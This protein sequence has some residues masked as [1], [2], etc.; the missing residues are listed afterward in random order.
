MSAL[1]CEL[2]KSFIPNASIKYSRA[3]GGNS[4][5]TGLRLLVSTFLKP[6]FG[7]GPFFFVLLLNLDEGVA[8]QR[9]VLVLRGVTIPC[10]LF[11]IMGGSVS[12]EDGSGCGS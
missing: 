11:I 6:R 4:F 10:V 1:L 3:S 2:A 12:I 7:G 8:L 5:L 9:G